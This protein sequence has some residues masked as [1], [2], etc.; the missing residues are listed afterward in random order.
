MFFFKFYLDD[1]IKQNYI[2]LQNQC[3]QL[4]NANRAWQQFYDNQ[5]EM[6]KNQFKDYLDFDKNLNFDQI[7]QMIASEFQK[8]NSP[9]GK[10]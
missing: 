7:I 10:I 8:Q 5:M 9:S 6:I 2:L 4:D 3:T 1:Q